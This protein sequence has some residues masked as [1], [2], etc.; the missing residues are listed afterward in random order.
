MRGRISQGK[1]SVRA[2]VGKF[3][4]GACGAAFPKGK[5][6]SVP[7]LGNLSGSLRGRISQGKKFVRAPVGKSVR[8]PLGQI[9]Q[10]GQIG[11]VEKSVRELA[12]PHFPREK[13]CPCPCWEIYP[14]RP[15]GLGKR[16]GLIEQFI[17]EFAG[18]QFP[19]GQNLCGPR[20][21]NLSGVVLAASGARAA[22]EATAPGRSERV[23]ERDDY[24]RRS[25][26]A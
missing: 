12:G 23:C 26:R 8:A 16:S 14:G 3:V 15:A 17:R 5:N 7:L 13:I 24:L 22:R 6:L 19:R 25:V 10:I 18:P 2:P 9:S 21:G 11:R 20:L 1:K 4:R